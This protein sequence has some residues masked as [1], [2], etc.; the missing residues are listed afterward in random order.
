[1]MSRTISW[2]VLASVAAMIGL[3]ACGGSPSASSSSTTQP[4]SIEAALGLDQASIQAREAKVQQAIATCMKSEGFDYIPIDPAAAGFSFVTFGGAGQDTS[5]YRKTKGY[6]ISTT[7]GTQRG[8]TPAKDPNEEIRSHLTDDERTA[9]DK[10]LYGAAAPKDTGAEGGG[11]QIRVGPGGADQFGELGCFGKA[12][13][14]VGGPSP[15]TVGPKLKELQDRIAADS[16]LVKANADWAACM[17]K[18]GYSQFTKPEEIIQYLFGKMAKVT[19]QDDSD[20][21]PASTDGISIQAGGPAK[22]D[23]K[24]L[25]AVQNEELTIAKADDSCSISTKRR[26]IA[27]KVREELTKQFLQENPNLGQTAQSSGS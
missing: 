6:G 1:M 3:G 23:E 15:E 10:A 17:N 5:E 27:K 16:R 21:G 18:S 19:G 26:D 4:D 20:S 14:S 24:A 25:A 8:T 11:V 9:Y 12:Q 22:I 13:Q 2:V 7:F